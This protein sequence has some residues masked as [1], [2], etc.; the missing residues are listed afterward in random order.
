VSYNDTS[1]Y[2]VFYNIIL[3]IFNWIH[4]IHA[5]LNLPGMSS[6]RIHDPIQSYKITLTR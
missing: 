6:L 5:C 2:K 3:Y 4:I 1:T